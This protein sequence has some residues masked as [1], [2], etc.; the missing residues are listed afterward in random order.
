VTDEHGSIV[1]DEYGRPVYHTDAIGRQLL[2]E[3]INS[4]DLQKIATITHGKFYRATDETQLH[5]IYDEIDQLEKTRALL[6][7]YSTFQELFYWPALLG[8]VLIGLEQLL[9]H[10][11]LRRLP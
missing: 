10:T 8:L 7:H 9:S 5:Q 3:G 2:Q 6:R 11:R 1:K 4:D